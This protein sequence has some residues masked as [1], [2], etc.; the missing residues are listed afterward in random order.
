MYELKSGCVAAA[1]THVSVL[2]RSARGMRHY[3]PLIASWS[4][5]DSLLVSES[6]F[7]KALSCCSAGVRELCLKNS[8]KKYVYL[9]VTYFRGNLPE[10]IWGVFF[11]LCFHIEMIMIAEQQ[12]GIYAHLHTFFFFLN[13]CIIIIII[14]HSFIIF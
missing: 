7:I 3:F 14:I 12:I 6:Q 9:P 1:L 10:I 5:A 4:G 11:F 13:D 2:E 8:D